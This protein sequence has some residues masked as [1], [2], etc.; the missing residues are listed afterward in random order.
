MQ[1]ILSVSASGCFVTNT[2]CLA[3]TD[4]ESQASLSWKSEPSW[5]GSLLKIQESP[6]VAGARILSGGFGVETPLSRSGDYEKGSVLNHSKLASSRST[7]SRIL[8]SFARLPSD[9]VAIS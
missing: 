7:V 6:S 4:E 5:L 3:C 1:F 9:P 8:D 2:A